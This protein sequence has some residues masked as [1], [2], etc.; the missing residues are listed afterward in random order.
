MSQETA[1][2][3]KTLDRLATRLRLKTDPTIFFVAA[4][5]MVGFLGLLLLFP[6]Q[7]RDVFTAARTWIV[8]NLGWFFIMGVSLWLLF[9]VLLALSRYGRIRLGADD[10]KPEYSNIS[11]FTMLFAGGIGTILMFWGGGGADL[12]RGGTAARRRGATFGGGC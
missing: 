9:L 2:P 11:W 10:A 7:T 8:T 12:P 6:G 3:T 1:R 4:A 5:C